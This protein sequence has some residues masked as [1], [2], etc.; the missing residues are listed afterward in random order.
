MLISPEDGKV[1]TPLGVGAMHPKTLTHTTVL[2]Y[3]IRH[4]T[5]SNLLITIDNCHESAA[6][7][8]RKASQPKIVHLIIKASK[9]EKITDSMGLGGAQ[10]TA[11]ETGR[12][13]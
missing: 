2:S 12:A 10:P 13:T 8:P 4:V 7:L 11:D 3:A 6:Y 9:K 1:W 5:S